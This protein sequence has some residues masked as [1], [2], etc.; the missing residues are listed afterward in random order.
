MSER[1]KKECLRDGDIMEKNTVLFGNYFALDMKTKVVRH[2][3]DVVSGLECNCIC[4]ECGERLIARKGK[5]REHHFAHAGS[6]VKDSNG[7]CQFGETLI[8]MLGKQII[9]E[10]AYFFLPRQ[11]YKDCNI[12]GDIQGKQKFFRENVRLHLQGGRYTVIEEEVDKN[13][14]FI[15]D[16]KIVSDRNIGSGK[17]I[18][19]EIKRTHGIEK[20]K[21]EY[22]IKNEIPTIEV[23]LS[24]DSIFEEIN[25]VEELR[26]CLQRIIIA[27]VPNEYLRWFYLPIAYKKIGKT[28][29]NESSKCLYSDKNCSYFC[30]SCIATVKDKSHNYCMYDPKAAAKDFE[31]ISDLLKYMQNE[32]INDFDALYI[33]DKKD[34]YNT[35]T[36]VGLL[37]VFGIKFRAHERL[38][39]Y[40]IQG[41]ANPCIIQ[42]DAEY[43][44]YGIITFNTLKMILKIKNRCS[45]DNYCIDENEINKEKE[46]LDKLAMK[47]RC[48]LEMELAV[49]LQA[50]DGEYFQNGKIVSMLQRENNLDISYYAIGNQ[51]IKEVIRYLGPVI[52]LKYNQKY[53]ERW[54]FH[55]CP[56]KSKT[57]VYHSNDCPYIG[58][59]DDKGRY[60][61]ENI[62]IKCGRFAGY[63][64]QYNYCI[65][66]INW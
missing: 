11:S 58:E 31:K 47:Y 21:K 45:Q 5:V 64:D 36:I 48:Y 29:L 24:D 19:I 37:D 13:L 65:S 9:K 14:R 16:I 51:N 17:Q 2:I 1:S 10:A 33:K 66:K 34:S 42:Q 44:N 53:G 26:E 60:N 20:A 56:Y 18:W 12:R 22:I 57:K 50:S 25:S 32:E 40:L 15:P 4:S 63:D 38:K 46:I 28:N 27:E 6:S 35:L 8:H 59:K 23:D 49:D 41:G 52:D 43:S 61:S 54:G 62:C 30:S 55:F 39:R 7:G 3:N